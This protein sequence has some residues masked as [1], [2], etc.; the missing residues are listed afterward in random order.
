[1]KRILLLFIIILLYSCF[2]NRDHQYWVEQIKKSNEILKNREIDNETRGQEMIRKAR[3]YSALNKNEKALKIWNEILVRNDT[4]MVSKARAQYRIGLLYEEQEDWYMAIKEYKKYVKLYSALTEDQQ[5]HFDYNSESGVIIHYHIGEIYEFK[6][7][8]IQLAE[9][10][11]LDAILNTKKAQSFKYER[12]EGLIGDFYFRH[13]NYENSL[14]YFLELREK[15][16]LDPRYS[17]IPMTEIIYK[18]IKCL[19]FLGRIEEAKTE[20]NKL[21]EEWGNTKVTIYKVYIER[22]IEFMEEQGIKVNKK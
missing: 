21:L 4:D 7:N 16:K 15:N 20:Y 19:Y 8:E 10:E 3:A 17:V 9:K 5:N 2:L 12:L 6:L 13:N 18:I 22:T 1:M 11:Y 14:K